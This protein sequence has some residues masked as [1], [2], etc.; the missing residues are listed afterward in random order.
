MMPTRMRLFVVLMARIGHFLGNLLHFSMNIHNLLSI[1]INTLV[2]HQVA[3]QKHITPV[4][5]IRMIY[6]QKNCR[7][8][9]FHWERNVVLAKVNLFLLLS[10]SQFFTHSHKV[11][12]NFKFRISACVSFELATGLNF[13]DKFKEPIDQY[14]VTLCSACPTT[15]IEQ[16]S[17][18]YT[19]DRT[20]DVGC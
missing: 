3:T 13:I 4:H 20:T 9:L 12:I 14:V 1:S 5:R 10:L 18:Y 17:I 11:S 16:E 6:A 2:T 7:L 15:P 19:T 8:R